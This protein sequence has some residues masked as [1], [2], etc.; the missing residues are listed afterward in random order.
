MK[1]I[2]IK[3]KYINN[4]HCTCDKCINYYCSVCLLYLMRKHPKNSCSRFVEGHRE[5]IDDDTLY[6]V[7]DKYEKIK[8][9]IS[10]L[11]YHM[12]GLKDIILKEIDSDAIVGDYKVHIS[13]IV[14]KRLDTEKVKNLIKDLPDSDSYFKTIK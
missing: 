2:T 6:N 8:M 9:Y 5:S 13:D 7:I 1:S 11:K 12:N 4:E 3:K 10:T 14:Q